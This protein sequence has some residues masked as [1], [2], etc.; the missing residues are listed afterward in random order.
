MQ[1]RKF[2]G[3]TS[4][5]LVVAVFATAAPAADWTVTQLT[6]NSYYD[7]NPQV[8]GNNV[9]WGG[10]AGSGGTNEIFFYNGTATSR[11]TNNDY[12]DS[13]PQVSGSNVV[14]NAGYTIYFYNGTST[15]QLTNDSDFHES[16]VVSG[17]NVA[18]TTTDYHIPGDNEYEYR[19]SFYDGTGISTFGSGVSGMWN[20]GGF[21]GG[22]AISGNNV[23]WLTWLGW[24]GYCYTTVHLYKDGSETVTNGGG[25]GGLEVPVSNCGISGNNVVWQWEDTSGG[26]SE[27]FLYD[28]TTTTQLTSDDGMHNNN[29]N[30]QVSGSNIVWQGHIWWVSNSEIFLYDGTTTTRLTDN[31]Y[32]DRNPQVSGDNIVWEGFDGNDYEIFLYDGTTI[33][34]LTD[35]DFDD[36]NPQIDGNTIVWE[37]NGEIFMAV[38]E[39]AT[40]SLLAVGG[41]ALLRRRQR[42]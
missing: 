26:T 28:G 1:M 36:L 30:P 12:D 3:I 39:P 15:T 35:N 10:S 42:K 31:S 8:S 17:N 41:L 23:A 7:G 16:P 25:G 33:T 6:N 11:L 20:P 29:T 21:A 4:F 34:Q 32:I 22:A 18:W 14:W 5:V 19:V 2:F 37:G 27:I 38:P 40:M 13:V 24:G 9:V